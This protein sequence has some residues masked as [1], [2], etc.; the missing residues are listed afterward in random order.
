[1]V[2]GW[3][4]EPFACVLDAIKFRI[5]SPNTDDHESIFLGFHFSVGQSGGV[6][7]L[8]GRAS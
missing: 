2:L 3:F 8:R 5:V 7:N 1:M 6:E 4:C